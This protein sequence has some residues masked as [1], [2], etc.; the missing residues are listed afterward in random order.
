MIYVTDCLLEVLSLNGHNSHKLLNFEYPLVWF[1][2]SSKS[3]FEFF[4]KYTLPKSLIRLY[5]ESI[6]EIIGKASFDV[7]LQLSSISSLDIFIPNDDKVFCNNS[8]AFSN[9]ICLGWFLLLSISIYSE[10][11]SNPFTLS[12]NKLSNCVPCEVKGFILSRYC[13][14]IA[15]R[16]FAKLL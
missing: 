12:F 15:V 11:S 2:Y 14:F 16:T 4:G 8:I 6:I 10:T 9:T 3:P 1:T 5:R 7:S 13:P